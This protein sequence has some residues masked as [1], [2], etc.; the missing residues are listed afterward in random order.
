M[1]WLYLSLAVVFEVISTS[2]LKLTYGFTVLLP[3]AGTVVGYFLCFYFLSLALKTMDISVAYAVW[4]SLG[5]I[6]ISLIGFFFFQEPLSLLKVM[7]IVLIIIGTL[8]L[9]LAS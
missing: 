8:G 5:T 3:S 4:C 1:E 7:C 9:R 2:L 6:L